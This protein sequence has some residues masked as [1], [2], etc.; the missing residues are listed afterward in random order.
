MDTQRLLLYMALGFLS[1]IMFQTW[2]QDYNATEIITAEVGVDGVTPTA[3]APAD[4]PQA[5]GTATQAVAPTAVAAAAVDTPSVRVVTD[6][7]DVSI[8]S[9]GGTIESVQL[10]DYS[11]SIEKPDEPFSLASTKPSKF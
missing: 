2:Q 7:L 6:V 8:S 5:A 10:L 9:I 11:V 3:P 4:L 1:L